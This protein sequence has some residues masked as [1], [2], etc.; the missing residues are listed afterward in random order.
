MRIS[1][2][3]YSMQKSSS[4]LADNTLCISY[5]PNEHPISI[6][7]TK[8]LNCDGYNIT[9]NRFPGATFGGSWQ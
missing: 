3:L 7:V 1:D 4:Y 6:D 8:H 5:E 2:Y 9:S